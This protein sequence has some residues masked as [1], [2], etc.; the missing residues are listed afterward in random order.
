MSTGLVIASKANLAL[1]QG[2]FSIDI[3]V[4]AAD[5]VNSRLRA[6]IAQKDGIRLD[7]YEIIDLRM[8]SGLIGELFSTELCKIDARLLKNPNIDGYPDLCDISAPGAAAR[9]KALTLSNFI[10]YKYGGFEVKNTF[11]VK[12]AKTHIVPR[13]TR[14]PKI[15]K[16][17]VWKAHHRKT[18]NL[19]AVQSDYIKGVPQLIAGFYSDELTEGDWTVKQQPRDGSTMTSFCQTTPAAFRKL[20]R[21]LKFFMEGIGH[22]QFINQ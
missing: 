5:T 9:A 12:K 1:V 3:L 11:G 4:R 22:E 7:L 20:K 13:E 10:A 14:L 6:A 19:I 17:L 16:A 15:Q 2:E 18:N 8:L 21:G